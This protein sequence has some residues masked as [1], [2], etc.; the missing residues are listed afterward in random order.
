MKKKMAVGALAMVSALGVGVTVLRHRPAARQVVHVSSYPLL[1]TP[2][3]AAR[4]TGNDL[5]FEA[6]VIGRRNTRLTTVDA[7]KGGS[8][9]APPI[10]YTYTPVE[11]VVTGVHVGDVGL[12]DKITIRSLGGVVDG[13]EYIFEGVPPL[14][15]YESGTELMLFTEY[16][17]DVDG[18][19]AA[20]PNFVYVVEKDKT[21]SP[22]H[23]EQT[24]TLDQLRSLIREA[25]PK[26]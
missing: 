15:I 6:R 21:H 4:F 5:I 22:V 24:A 13:K 26:P 8:P 14:E 2:Q 9:G 19:A 20:T 23:P 16:I 3:E 18:I 1:D 25:H 10:E 12:G 11:V 17:I 7:A